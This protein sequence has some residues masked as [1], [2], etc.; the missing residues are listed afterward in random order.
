M[1]KIKAV[2]FDLDG[3]L[4]DSRSVWTNLDAEFLAGRGIKMPSDYPAAVSTMGFR[5]SAE[6]T[7]QRFGLPDRPES[8]MREWF[9]MAQGLYATAVPAKKGVKA[10]LEKLKSQGILLGVATANAENLFMPCLQRNEI[11]SLFDAFATVAETPTGKKDG[12]VYRLC[13]QKLGVE[14]CECAVFED[15]FVGI[16]FAKESNFYTVG[17]KDAGNQAEWADILLVA[18]ECLTDF[19]DAPHLK[20]WNALQVF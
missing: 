2:L 8:L 6:Y 17:V 3:T 10:F 19:E 9:A 13:A 5:A 14:P 15:L 1:K 16:Q 11:A 20:L 18:D 4:L 12:Q 7:I